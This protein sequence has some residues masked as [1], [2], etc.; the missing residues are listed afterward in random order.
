M[1][2][3]KFTLYKY[4]KLGDGLGATK[5]LPSTLTAKLSPTSSSSG[6]THRENLSSKRTQRSSTL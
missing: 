4:V 3:S 6:R 5:G 1:A 2:Q